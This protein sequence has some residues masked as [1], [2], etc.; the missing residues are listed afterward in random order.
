MSESLETTLD[1]I[2]AKAQSEQRMPSV[3]AA[4]GRDGEVLWRRAMGRADVE[5]GEPA[6]TD[7]VYRIGSITKTFTAVAILQL[8]EA[9]RLQLDDPVRKLLPEFP[10]GPTIRQALSHLTGIQREPPG[11]IWESMIPPSREELVGGLEDA[12]QILQPG[13]AWHYSKIGRAHV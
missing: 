5:R 10:A 3:S 11:E 2:L 13:Q 7:H 6:T 12:E 4:V 9:G 8:R 1:G